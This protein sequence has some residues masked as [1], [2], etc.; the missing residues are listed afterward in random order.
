[1]KKIKALF[2]FKPSKRRFSDSF[3]DKTVEPHV[4]WTPVTR[5]RRKEREDW[6]K[7]ER[8]H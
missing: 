3:S 1:M 7:L 2:L 8:K 4:K 5:G 6:G